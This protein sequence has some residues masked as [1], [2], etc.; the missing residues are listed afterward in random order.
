MLAG[1]FWGQFEA[2]ELNTIAS[3]SAGSVERSRAIGNAAG[4]GALCA[5]CRRTTSKDSDVVPAH[6]LY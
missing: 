5:S 2:R 1:A 6:R 4:V 3:S